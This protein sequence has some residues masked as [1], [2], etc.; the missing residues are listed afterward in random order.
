MNR[1]TRFLTFANCLL[2][3]GGILSDLGTNIRLEAQPIRW[4]PARI[5]ARCIDHCKRWSR[6]DTIVFSGVAGTITLTSTLSINKSV[7]IN[8]PGANL[9]TISGND[10]VRVFTVASAQTF[11]ISGLTIAHGFSTQGAGILTAGILTVNNCTFSNNV[12][13][14]GG[15]SNIRGVPACAERQLHLHRQ[16]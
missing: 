2:L 16:C 8:G 12:A 11:A 7:T 5:L 9:L 4:I 10:A 13:T 15:Q 14:K 6:G 3:T 1:V